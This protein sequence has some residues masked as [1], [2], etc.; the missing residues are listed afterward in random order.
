MN[1]Q[2]GGFGHVIV[3]SNRDPGLFRAFP[4]LEGD[5]VQTIRIGSHLPKLE[6]DPVA[7]PS[8]DECPTEVVVH[9]ESSTRRHRQQL[10]PGG[11]GSQGGG[12]QE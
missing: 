8:P 1:L 7:V 10:L 5:L 4:G 2:V 9:L 12:S 3:K 6:L 11:F